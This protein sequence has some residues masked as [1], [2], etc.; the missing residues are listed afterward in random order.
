[1]LGARVNGMRANYFIPMRAPRDKQFWRLLAH[2]SVVTLGSG[3]LVSGSHLY[4]EWAQAFAAKI[5]RV[6]AFDSLKWVR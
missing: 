6:V 3:R 2:S 1:M 5:V 4:C